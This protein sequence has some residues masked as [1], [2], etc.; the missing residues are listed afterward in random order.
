MAG[1]EGGPPQA[2]LDG[3]EIA[4][5]MMQATEAASAAAQMAAQALHHQQQARAG[6]EPFW[7]KTLP[8]PN[9]FNPSSREEELSLW[10]DFSWGL[11]QHLASL[12]A[13]SRTCGSALTGPWTL[14]FG[15][16]EKSKEATS[17]TPSWRPW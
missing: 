10:R 13:T 8:K 17:C 9:G 5:R 16:I 4:R 12:S 15:V 7:F 11:E 2:A 1:Q 3:S 14:R 6:N